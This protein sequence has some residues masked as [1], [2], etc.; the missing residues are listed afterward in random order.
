[1]AGSSRPLNRHGWNDGSRFEQISATTCCS[2][3]AHTRNERGLTPKTMRTCKAMSSSDQ[4]V[5]S[6]ISAEK[7]TLHG[8]CSGLQITKHMPIY[9][10]TETCRFV[11]PCPS[12]RRTLRNRE[13][14]AAGGSRLGQTAPAAAVAS[15][16]GPSTAP[17]GLPAPTRASGPVPIQAVSKLI[18]GK[19]GA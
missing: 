8:W 2:G 1:M 10:A 18:D 12:S 7:K 6:M 4:I 19:T 17:R 9:P 3:K 15:G 14:K 16:G 11:P 13:G 5:I